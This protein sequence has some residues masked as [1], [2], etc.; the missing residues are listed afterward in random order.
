M[1]RCTG[2][3]QVKPVEDFYR[4]ARGKLSVYC[5]PCKKA[6][7]AVSADRMQHQS[8]ADVAERF[9]A[10][11]EKTPSCWV[12]RGWT[13]NVGY[14]RFL[15]RG[16]ATQAHVVSLLIA[17]VDVPSRWDTGLVV[18]HLCRNPACVNPAHLRIVP[19][20]DN[21][22]PLANPTPHW[23]NKTKTHCIKGHPLSGANLAIYR[24]PRGKPVRSCLTCE[25]AKWMWAVIERGPPEGVKPRKQWRGPFRKDGDENRA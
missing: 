14:G 16:R 25:P 4:A 22:G 7:R 10:K 9:F 2:C 6:A 19:Q 20:V 21:C 17:G 23:M 13:G 24:D 5:K 1:K 12:W 3:E 11:V 15:F 18:D 8:P